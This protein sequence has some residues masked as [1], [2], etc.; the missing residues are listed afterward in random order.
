[1]LEEDIVLNQ[2]NTTL[3]GKY[4]F[5]VG[6]RFD[7]NASVLAYQAQVFGPKKKNF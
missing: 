6:Q 2:Q 5:Y 4:S 7:T 3:L 1:M